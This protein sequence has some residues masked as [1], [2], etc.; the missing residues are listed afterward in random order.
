[1]SRPSVKAPT[2]GFAKTFVW[3]ALLIFAVPAAS[4]WFFNHVE[5]SFDADALQGI[6]QGVNADDGLSPE[7]KTAAIQ[8]FTENPVSKLEASGAVDLDLPAQLRFYYATFRWM[9]R[10]S[11]WSLAAGLIVLALVGACI[12]ISMRSPP[13]QYLCLSAGWH[14]LRIYGAFQAIVTGVLLIALSFWVTAF[15]FEAYFVKLIII[16]GVLALAGIGAVIAGI[17]KRTPIVNR[18]AGKPA[19]SAANAPLFQRLREICDKVGT[20]PPDNVILGIDNNFFVTELPVTVNDQTYEGRTLFVSLSLLKQLHDEEADA[21]LAHEMAHFSGNDTLYSK[22]IA[23]LLNKYAHYLGSLR[24]GGAALPVFYFMNFF[25]A[26][27]ELSLSRLS[28]EREFRADR[29]AREATSA[30]AVAGALTRVIAYAAY[31][32]KVEQQLFEE[33]VALEEA[34]VAERIEQG[35][36]E[37]AASFLAQPGAGE[38]ELAHPF[39]THPPLAQRLEAIGLRLEMPETRSLLALAG[40]GRWFERIADAAELERAQWDEFEE[41]FRNYHEQSLPYRYLP[42]TE[43]ERAV[44]VRHFPAVTFA[45]KEGALTI[46]FEKL[47]FAKWSEPLLF[48]EVRQFQLTDGGELQISFA[49]GEKGKQK[50][51]IKLK[52]FPNQQEIVDALNR[53]WGRYQSAVAYRR[54]LAEGAANEAVKSDA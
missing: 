24:Q 28:R 49:R 19:V 32:R 50:T 3:P 45:G 42:A 35:F 31:R 48:A 15:W 36:P 34:N 38:V 6:I 53:Y 39:D 29:I 23:P 51:A 16:A 7:E 26:L 20:T 52:K 14:V 21:I 9:I 27:F 25:R 4:L 1:M 40:N 33:E 11:L 2:P 12:P 13:A 46:D 44:V 30:P 22:K 8:F 47:S 5:A 43:E 41:Q 17:F 37:F 18:V 10:L 54:Q